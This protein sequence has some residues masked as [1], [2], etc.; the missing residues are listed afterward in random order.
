MDHNPND[1][2][3]RM[4]D[5]LAGLK[6]EERR[7]VPYNG[8]LGQKVRYV[9]CFCVVF[10]AL[11]CLQQREWLAKELDCDCR[12]IVATHVPFFPG[13]CAPECLSWDF[14]GERSD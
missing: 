12:V 6:G 5:W 11:W 10:D 9:V 2:R 1:V 14:P 13:S 8:A 3:S 7:F 4:V